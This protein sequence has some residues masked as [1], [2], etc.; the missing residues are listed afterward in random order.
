MG[1]VLTW[2]DRHGIEFVCGIPH[3]DGG[4]WAGN[5]RLFQSLSKGSSLSRMATQLGMLLAGG[6]DGGLFIM[7]GRKASGR[8]MTATAG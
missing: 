4:A 7:I 3:P 5:E 6:S 2:F 8:L 1:E